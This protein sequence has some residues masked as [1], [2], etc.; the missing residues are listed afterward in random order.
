MNN[1]AM[2]DAIALDVDQDHVF[3]KYQLINTGAKC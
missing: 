1:D 3:Y 2:C